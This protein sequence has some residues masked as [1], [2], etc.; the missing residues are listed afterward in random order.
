MTVR[1]RLVGWLASARA[2]DSRYLSPLL[3][4]TWKQKL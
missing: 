2:G 4:S 3:V 1:E